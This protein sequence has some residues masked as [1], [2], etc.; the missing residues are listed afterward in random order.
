MVSGYWIVVETFRRNVC[1]RLPERLYWLLDSSR[2]VPP[3]RLY[4]IAGTSVRD[5]RNVCTRLPERL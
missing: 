5:C 4:E 1:T 2:D 3:E